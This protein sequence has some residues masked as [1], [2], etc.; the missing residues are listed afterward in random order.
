MH[1]QAAEKMSCSVILSE[2]KNL[3]SI[4]VSE[5]KP[6]EILRFAQNDSVFNFSVVCFTNPDRPNG[7]VRN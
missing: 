6:G 7:Q 3:S 5:N 1:L 2:A 4:Y